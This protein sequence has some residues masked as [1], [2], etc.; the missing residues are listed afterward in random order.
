LAGAAGD[1]AVAVETGMTAG[2]LP[3][4]FFAFFFPLLPTTDRH[5]LRLV[6][7]RRRAV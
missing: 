5:T 1:E 3:A 4:A 7:A 2:F 6:A